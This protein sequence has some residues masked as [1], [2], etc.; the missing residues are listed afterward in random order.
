[1]A[2]RTPG[3]VPKVIYDD[4]SI[5]FDASS[6][7]FVPWHALKGVVNQSI[8]K[9]AKYRHQDPL[10]DREEREKTSMQF[11]LKYLLAIT[12]SSYARE[13][14]KGKRRSK[15]HVYPDDWKQLP[16]APISPEAQKPFIALVDKILRE[17]KQQSYPLAAASAEKVAA[18]ERELDEM[19][20]AL[21]K[22]GS[23]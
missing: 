13:W 11:N 7:G 5:H 19:V 14:L 6:V 15:M 16:V 10:G 23:V 21:Y 17:Y 18:W 12:N 3:V 2:I 20:D 22:S 8:R 1:M 9:S 4:D